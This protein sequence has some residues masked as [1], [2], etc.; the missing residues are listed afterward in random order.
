MLCGSRFTMCL[1]LVAQVQG[2]LCFTALHDGNFRSACRQWCSS[3]GR[4]QAE[5]VYGALKDWQVNAVTD[6]SFA[7]SGCGALTNELEENNWNTAAVTNMRGTL[8]AA[9]P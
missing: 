9:H 5:S 4:A 8:H 7:F 2:G 6:M 3:N 1:L